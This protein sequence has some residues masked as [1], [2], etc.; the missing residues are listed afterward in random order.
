MLT[1]ASILSLISSC[2]EL[3]ASASL[4][5][6]GFGLGLVC[7]RENLASFNVADITL[8]AV[9]AWTEARGG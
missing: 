4:R 8:Y 6:H 2:F 5:P 3:L 7:G 1:K 9:G